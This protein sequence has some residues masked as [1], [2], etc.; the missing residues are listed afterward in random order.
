MGP[1]EVPESSRSRYAT[2]HISR[3]GVTTTVMMAVVLLMLLG[4][5]S[6]SAS[7][8]PI[9]EESFRFRTAERP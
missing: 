5:L 3:I 9:L 1:P 7:P 6:L 4:Y 8:V 2:L